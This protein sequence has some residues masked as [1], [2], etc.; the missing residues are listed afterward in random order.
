MRSWASLRKTS[1]RSPSCQEGCGGEKAAEWGKACSSGKQCLGRRQRGWK[2]WS[3]S[4][5]G[6]DYRTELESS[7]WERTRSGSLQ[8]P[9]P[10]LPQA[11]GFLRE[12]SRQVAKGRQEEELWSPRFVMSVR[13]AMSLRVSGG[14]LW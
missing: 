12:G 2:G 5:K 7:V 14:T 11:S 13:D 1:F 8:L 9:P 3:V 6:P 10:P 4:M